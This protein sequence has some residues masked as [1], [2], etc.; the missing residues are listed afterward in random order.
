[1]GPIALMNIVTAIMVESSLRTAKEDLDA[2]KAWEEMK[3]KS[4]KPRLIRLFH[5]LDADASGEVDMKEIEKAPAELQ[6]QLQQIVD[7]DD[8]AETFNMLDVDGSGVVSI[9][10]FVD[11][12]MRSQTDKPSELTVIIKQGKSIL[13]HLQGRAV[14]ASR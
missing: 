8:L 5:S 10:E 14:R 3:R 6:E 1:M 13:Q 7:L 4:L 2:R 11:G 9:D 12:I